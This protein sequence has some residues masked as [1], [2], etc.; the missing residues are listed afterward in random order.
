MEQ[1]ETE[2]KAKINRVKERLFSVYI[3]NETTP[4]DYERI[5]TY[6]NFVVKAARGLYE[7]Q[8]AF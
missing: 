2:H 1:N 6:R 8:D 7:T 5:E 3:K 4:I